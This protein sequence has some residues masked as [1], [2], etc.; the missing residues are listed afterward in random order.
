MKVFVSHSNKDISD[1]HKLKKEML[2]YG[3][4]LFLAHEDI[5]PGE[6]DLE[7]IKKEVSECDVFLIIGN[8]HS[9]LSE[10]CNQEIGMAVA[11]KKDIISTVHINLSPWGFIQRQQAIKYK[12]ILEDLRSKLLEH[13]TQIEKYKDH[14]A[15]E[16]KSLEI[17]KIKG[18]SVDKLKTD[19]INLKMSMWDDYGYQTMFEIIRKNKKIGYVRIGYRNQ[20]PST[21]NKSTPQ[22]K[23]KLPQK[24][25]FFRKQIFF[26]C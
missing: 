16:L 4:Y 14:W 15:S 22:I 7:R 23:D 12:N 6:H 13:I 11:H 17:L 21:Q 8:E 26:L 1:L 5:K 10:F 25:L 20:T 19:Y 24:F 3:I 2:G 9:K 18:F